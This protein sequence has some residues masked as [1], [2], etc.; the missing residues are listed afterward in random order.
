MLCCVALA[1]AAHRRVHE[2]NAQSLANTAWAFATADQSHALLFAALARA[3]QRRVGEFNA[4]NLANT[5]WA[6]ATADQSDVLL[7]AALVRAALAP[8]GRVQC[9]GFRQ[10]RM[11]ICSSAQAGAHAT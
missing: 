9:A 4:Q 3:A 5:V 7:F 8:R 1:G 6:F 11:G 2:F 10:H